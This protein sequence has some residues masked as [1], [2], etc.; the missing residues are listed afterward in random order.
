[1]FGSA[2]TCS[3]FCVVAMLLESGPCVVC[4]I[5]THC[6]RT[7]MLCS[8][9]VCFSEDISEL[10]VFSPQAGVTESQWLA[11]SDARL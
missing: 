6:S 1:M 9:T 4:M 5:Y 11:V 7:V 3:A 10:R 8:Y 2:H